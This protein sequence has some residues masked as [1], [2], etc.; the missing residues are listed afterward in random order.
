MVSICKYQASVLEILKN[1]SPPDTHT[2]THMHTIRDNKQVKQSCRIQN[3]HTSPI[4]FLYISMD[5][6]K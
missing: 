2:Q 6:Q 4:L 1:T 5:K 3:Q